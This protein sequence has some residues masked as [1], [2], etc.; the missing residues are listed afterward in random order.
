MIAPWRRLSPDWSSEGTS[1]SQA[2]SCAGRWKR[3]KSPISRQSTNA[4]RRVD[5]AEAAQP[6]DGRPPLAL[7][8]E[9]GEPLV[10]RGLAGDAARRRRRARRGRRAR[11]RARRT[12]ARRAT[13]GALRPGARLRVDAAVQQQQLRDAV[14]A[15]HQIAAHLLARAGRDDGPPRTLARRHRDRLQLTGEQQPREQLGVLAVGL[16][17]VA[18]RARRLDS[19]RS[20]RRA[21]RPPPPPGRARTRS[22]PPRSS[23]AAAAAAPQPADHLL[24]AAAEASTTKLTRSRRR[25][26]RHGSSGHGHPGPRTSSLRSRPDPP[27]VTWGQP[28]PVSGQTNP[29][30]VTERVRPS[31]RS[32]LLSRHRV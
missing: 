24:A 22:G 12:A 19:A 8:R 21:A 3:A 10:E 28:E 4:V 15:A 32:R 6:G 27:S 23:H 31:H 20:R 1:P 9:P 16:D 18:R 29:R 30:S 13:G 2:A 11:S 5:A 14:T 7:E 26:R 17:P 25:S